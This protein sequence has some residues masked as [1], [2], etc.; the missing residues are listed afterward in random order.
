MEQLQDGP[1]VVEAGKDVLDLGSFELE[2]PFIA[3]PVGV[4]L[5]AEEKPVP[6][7]NIGESWTARQGTMSPSSGFRS[8]EMGHFR[9]SLELHGS[10]QSRAL[11]AFDRKS[12]HGAL[13]TWDPSK[14]DQPL[15]FCLQPSVRVHGRFET[16]A[17][18]EAPPWTNVYITVALSEAR[19]GK[20]E[21]HDERIV[22]CQSTEANFDLRLPPGTYRFDGYGT[23][24]LGVKR[25]LVLTADQ[26]ELDLGV[27]A[28]PQTVIARN[29]GKEALPWKLSEAR[30]LSKD[31]SLADFR[32]K[33][34][35]LEFWG[36]W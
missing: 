5:D 28:L 23:N 24:T 25:Q 4:V 34:V 29:V 16:A 30:G 11:L 26:K 21:E 15:E 17:T 14:P 2:L 27:V 18:K 20:L 12:E 7:A 36:F 19:D 8:D 22:S 35:V 13:A 32:G 33:W 9:G 1:L 10:P 31:A 3:H 6:D